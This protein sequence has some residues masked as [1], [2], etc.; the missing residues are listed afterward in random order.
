[1]ELKISIGSELNFD[2][3]CIL[4]NNIIDFLIEYID[5]TQPLIHIIDTNIKN[6]FFGNKA[7]FIQNKLLKDVEEIPISSIFKMRLEDN[8]N[9]NKNQ[10]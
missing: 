3:L 1:M 2:K 4:S 5:T 10:K 9:T 6:L 7:N 8:S